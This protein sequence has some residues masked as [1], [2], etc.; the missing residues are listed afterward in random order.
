[1]SLQ[2]SDQDSSLEDE[3]AKKDPLGDNLDE[4]HP[5]DDFSK[6]RTVHYYSEWESTVRTPVFWINLA[7][8]QDEGLR[9]RPA[10]SHAV[11]VYS[12]VPA[13]CIYQVI[14]QKGERNFI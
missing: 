9:F 10:R 8:A 7:R 11:I 12:S 3:K 1:M 4:E 13:E 6:P 2:T 14:S 5:C